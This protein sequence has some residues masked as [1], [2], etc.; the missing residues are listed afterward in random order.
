MVKKPPANAGDTKDAGSTPGVGRS[1]GGGHG[2]PLQ[3]SGLESPMDRGAWRA[4]VHRV[5]KSCL[6]IKW[7]CMLWV[8]TL[9][10]YDLILIKSAKTLSPE[11]FFLRFW[12]DKS[13]GGHYSTH[14]SQLRA[15]SSSWGGQRDRAKTIIL[16]FG[17][18]SSATDTIPALP[19]PG[20]ACYTVVF[21]K[22][23]K[24]QKKDHG[25]AISPSFERRK[26][27]Q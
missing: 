6:W 17:L 25:E 23:M 20:S 27:Q 4:I 13:F 9:I 10:Y 19:T 12:V 7:L 1:S 21:S 15:M 22:P 18:N 26:D 2:N 16:A 8:H 3:H 24:A 14:S 11:K 5:A